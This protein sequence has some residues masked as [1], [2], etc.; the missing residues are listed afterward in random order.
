MI[1]IRVCSIEMVYWP[2]IEINRYHRGVVDERVCSRSISDTPYLSLAFFVQYID[3]PAGAVRGTGVW[4]QQCS[5][6]LL[7]GAKK[8]KGRGCIL[9]L[10]SF[11]I[12]SSPLSLLPLPYSMGNQQTPI[13]PLLKTVFE[14]SLAFPVFTSC[15]HGIANICIQ[16]YSL[17]L[18]YFCYV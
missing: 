10:S 18:R 17:F 13:G 6:P 2:I 8:I 12:P 3:L 9:A 1:W 15:R 11:C 5:L 14:A 7:R 4:R 16:L